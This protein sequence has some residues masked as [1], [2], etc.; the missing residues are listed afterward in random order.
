MRGEVTWHV[1]WTDR[2]PARVRSFADCRG[3]GEAEGGPGSGP[4]A[5]SG[6]RAVLSEPGEGSEAAAVAPGRVLRVVVSG[7]RLA[8]CGPAATVAE[9][10]A[11]PGRRGVDAERGLDVP[12][13]S[14][15]RE[16]LGPAQQ[17]LGL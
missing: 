12:A 10:G 14:Q 5:V 6:P 1:E 8:T 3:E 17:E 11:V 4:D 2:G 9:G 7:L 15:C 13:R 16:A